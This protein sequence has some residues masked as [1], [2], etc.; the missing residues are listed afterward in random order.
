[1]H[2]PRAGA[3]DPLVRRFGAFA[4]ERFPLA[5]AAALAA[6]DQ[7]GGSRADG[8]AAIEALRPALAAALRRAFPP[9]PA[10]DDITPGVTSGQRMAAAVDE[11]VEAC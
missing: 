10:L 9:L 4:A 7:A 8:E 1:M 3:A 6:F 5:A 11:I 2:R